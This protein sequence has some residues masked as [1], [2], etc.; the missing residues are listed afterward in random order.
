MMLQ[1]NTAGAWKNVVTFDAARRAEVVKAVGNLAGILGDGA[2][3]CILHEGGRREWL[4]FG[5]PRA[6]LGAGHG[7]ASPTEHL[8]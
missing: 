2:R 1:I 8:L 7:S 4:S 6:R 3:W 5:A